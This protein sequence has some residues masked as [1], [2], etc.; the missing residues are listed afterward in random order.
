MGQA[1][2]VWEF[3][4][5]VE[6]VGG[7]ETGTGS[8]FGNGTE[9]G[10]G[11]EMMAELSQGL[12]VVVVPSGGGGLLVGA[13][14]VCKGLQVKGEKGPV[15]FG[16]E[17]LVGGPGLGGRLRDYRGMEAARI[18]KGD[19]GGE[20]S[21][22]LFEREAGSGRQTAFE[23]DRHAARMENGSPEAQ[24]R[25]RDVAQSQTIAEGL[26]SVTGK[27]NWEHIKKD[28]NVR[29]V[30]A[31]SEEHIKAALRLCIEELGVVVEPSAAVAFAAALFD[32]DFHK[33]VSALGMGKRVKVG[34]VLTGGNVSREDLCRLLPGLKREVMEKWGVE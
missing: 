7:T 2:A 26:R 14:A 16:A 34:I 21:D 5:Q 30:F 12:D 24:K 10:T 9:I 6:R 32:A 31:V 33:Q 25:E 8:G 22:G 27:N 11:N 13:V 1:G 20:E 17:P 23:H 28:G 18:E 4:G 29:D 15:V 19:V 3:V